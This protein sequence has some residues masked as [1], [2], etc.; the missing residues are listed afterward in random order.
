MEKRRRGRPSADLPDVPADCLPCVERAH[1]AC[2]RVAPDGGGDGG[3]D[4]DGGG[5]DDGGVD[6]AGAANF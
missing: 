2:T 4:G 5:G 6:A 1:Y 3:G